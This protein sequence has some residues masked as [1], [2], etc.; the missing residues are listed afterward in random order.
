MIDDSF[1]SYQISFH[2]S[3]QSNWWWNWLNTTWFLYLTHALWARYYEDGIEFIHRL[4]YINCVYWAFCVTSVTGMRISGRFDMNSF[5]TLRMSE[6][7]VVWHAVC[8]GVA[9]CG[10][11]TKNTSQRLSPYFTLKRTNIIFIDMSDRLLVCG[12]LSEG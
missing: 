8:V 4:L 1:G 5:D 11:Q 12:L 2:F 9:V 3:H 10:V 6:R 7:G